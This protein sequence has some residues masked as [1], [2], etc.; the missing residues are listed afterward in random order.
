VIEFACRQGASKREQIMGRITKVMEHL[1]AEAVKEM[2]RNIRTPYTVKDGRSSTPR[3][4][5]QERR[6]R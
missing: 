4:F 3:K 2:M 6:K 1:P 5:I